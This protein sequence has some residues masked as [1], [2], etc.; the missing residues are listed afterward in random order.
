MLVSRLSLSVCCALSLTGPA[1]GSNPLQPVP[2]MADP[3]VHVW[4]DG[5]A[6]MYATHDT[7][8]GAAGELGFRMDN[9]WVFSSSDLVSWT[10]EDILWPTTTY[11]HKNDTECWATD[12]ATNGTHYAFYL[13]VGPNNIG[14]VV[15]DSPGGPW[16]DPLGVP[17]VAAGAVPNDGIR[18]PAAFRDDDGTTYLIFGTFDYFVAKLNADLVTLAEAPVG[19]LVVDHAFGPFG[20]GKLD[21]KPFMHKRFGMY[22]LS[23]GCFYGVGASPYGPFAYAGVIFD[24]AYVAPSFRRPSDVQ[25]DR[26]GSFFALHGQ[27]YFSANERSHGGRPDFRSSVIAVVDY[28]ANGTIAPLLLDETGVGQYNVSAPELLTGRRGVLQAERFFRLSGD[29]ARKAEMVGAPAAPTP[30]PP[31]PSLSAGMSLQLFDC[32][33]ATEWIVEAATGGGGGGGSSGGR[34]AGAFSIRAAANRSLCVTSLDANARAV[35]LQPCGGASA[36]QL[37]DTQLWR[38]GTSGNITTGVDVASASSTGV[39][40]QTQDTNCGPHNQDDPSQPQFHGADGMQVQTYSCAAVNHNQKWELGTTGGPAKISAWRG[41]ASGFCLDA[42]SVAPPPPRAQFEVVGLQAGAELAFPNVRGMPPKDGASFAVRVSNGNAHGGELEIRAGA[43]GSSK[44]PI[45]A[46]CPIVPTGSWDSYSV[47]Q[48]TRKPGVALSTE[49]NLTL[50]FSS[51][52]SPSAG[53]WAHLDFV[54]VV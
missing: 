25:I 48:C 17:L 31:A 27:E 54:T 47:T 19:P 43:S 49:T 42:G 52:T 1:L 39:C 8:D 46:S 30:A 5:K 7:P 37:P 33:G 24:N 11:E 29:G 10:Q 28:C 44:D 53:E 16:H 45:V 15:A 4:A 50:T 12:A 40:M 26:H 9:W 51:T 18:D 20:P 32:A 21:D 3:H 23:W 38:S 13:S 2:G 14:V 34:A 22:Y 6:W 41:F 36:A 35:Q